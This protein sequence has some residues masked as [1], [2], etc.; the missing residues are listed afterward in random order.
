MKTTTFA[1]L[2]LAIAIITTPLLA[3]PEKSP[4]MKREFMREHPQARK[5]MKMARKHERKAMKHRMKARGEMREWSMDNGMPPFGPSFGGPHCP[6]PGFNRGPMM[7]GPGFGPGPQQGPMWNPQ[8]RGPSP[9]CPQKEFCPNPDGPIQK[10][11]HL[12]QHRAF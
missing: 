7:H 12:R 1:T 6:N 4:Q 10:R 11:Q 8:M 2:A 9:D 5:H 3:Q